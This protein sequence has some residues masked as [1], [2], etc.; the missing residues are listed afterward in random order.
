ML[1]AKERAAKL[2]VKENE[3]SDLRQELGR[4]E[5]KLESIGK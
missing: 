4:L 2:E 3:I 5:G 1:T